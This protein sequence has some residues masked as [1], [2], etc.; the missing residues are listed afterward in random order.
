MA[1]EVVSGGETLRLEIELH[2]AGAMKLPEV[3]A[4]IA[5]VLRNQLRVVVSQ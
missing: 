4:N 5:S 3:V 1:R 2:L